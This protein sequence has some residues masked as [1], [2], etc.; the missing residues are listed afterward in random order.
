MVKFKN[1]WLFERSEFQMFLN[2][3]IAQYMAGIRTK[4]APKNKRKKHMSSETQLRFF[5]RQI[6]SVAAGRL[7]SRSE[8][9]EAYKQIILNEQPELQQ[10][11]FLMA[12][13]TRGPTTEELSGAWDAINKHD[14]SKINAGIK[15]PVCDIVG[16]GSDSLKTVNC[17]TPASFIAAAS[18]LT[19]AKKGA[20]LVT[21]VSGASDIMEILG[22]NLDAPL[23]QAE[24]SLGK[25]GICYLPGEVFLKSGWARLI[26]T[27]RF[28]SVF[29]IIGPLTFPCS[30]TSSIVIGGYSPTVC[31][32]LIDVHLGAIAGG[33][34]IDHVIL[35]LCVMNQYPVL[36]LF[37]IISENKIV[38]FLCWSPMC[39]CGHYELDI[40]MFR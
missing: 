3:I 12:H 19:I 32:Q 6:C 28:T 23:S 30:Q 36:E 8:S 1:L 9:Y 17:S 16:T 26:R 38:F 22:I 31:D 25:Y 33:S 35:Y 21:G 20:R 18:G 13:I 39:A 40:W 27:M 7:M 5:G 2:F 24:K 34:Q 10:G 15:G 37:I 4:G 29:N 14:T 11:A